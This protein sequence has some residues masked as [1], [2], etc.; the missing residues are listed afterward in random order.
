MLHVQQQQQQQ[1]SA[2]MLPQAIP[3]AGNLKYKSEMCKNWLQFGSCNY[4]QSCQFA[5]SE[6]RITYFH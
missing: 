5:H 6:A 3:L 4:S 2:N 1:N